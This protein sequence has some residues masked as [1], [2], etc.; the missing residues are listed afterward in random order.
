MVTHK[1]LLIFDLISLPIMFCLHAQVSVMLAYPE[2]NCDIPK[3]NFKTKFEKILLD[4]IITVVDLDFKSWRKS[5]YY[6]KCMAAIVTFKK[7]SNHFSDNS[8]MSL[9]VILWTILT[10]FLHCLKD[11]QIFLSFFSTLKFD[12]QNS[13]FLEI[14]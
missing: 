3:S 2:I 8:F 9:D 7:T 1:L 13:L 11:Q 6:D 5:S 12:F 10:V 4:N 14:F